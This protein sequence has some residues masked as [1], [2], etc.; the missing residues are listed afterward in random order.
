MKKQKH[1][2]H[3][4]DSAS[5]DSLQREPEQIKQTSVLSPAYQRRKLTYWLV[6]NTLLAGVYYY[7][8][9]YYWMRMTLWITV[10]LAIGSLGLILLVPYFLRRKTQKVQETIDQIKQ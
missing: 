10:P 1:Q 8:W 6:R 4:P 7:F 2:T 5:P 9:D 3:S